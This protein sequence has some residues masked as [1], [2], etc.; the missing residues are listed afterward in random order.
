M[1]KWRAQCV[2]QVLSETTW[3]HNCCLGGDESGPFWN[4]TSCWRCS[5]HLSCGSW[6]Q[7]WLLA[8]GWQFAIYSFIHFSVSIFLSLPFP[9]PPEQ[10]VSAMEHNLVYG[11]VYKVELKWCFSSL[12]TKLS[13]LSTFPWFFIFEVCAKCGINWLCKWSLVFLMLVNG[14]HWHLIKTNTI[15]LTRNQNVCI[16]E[17]VE[18]LYTLSLLSSLLRS[19]R[20]HR[21]CQ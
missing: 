15:I 20:K 5:R 19:P 18:L 14:V 21:K 12:G 2:K 13:L 4:A 7:P 1:F 9:F 17:N 6:F 3:P 8:D 11:L 10:G 16:F